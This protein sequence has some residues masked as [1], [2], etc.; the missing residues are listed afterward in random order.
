MSLS[1]VA[2]VL[3]APLIGED[4]VF[5]GVSTD[6]RSLQA[7][8]LFVAL[9]G[10]SYDGHNFLAAAMGAG[11]VGAIVSRSVTTPLPH[12]MTEDTRLA[13]GDLAAFWRRRFTVPVIAVTGSNGK[14]TVKEM[15]AAAMNET[16]AGLVTEGN[17]NNE[18][19]VPLTLLRLRQ[20]D[21]YAVVEMGMNHRGEIYYLTMLTRP[22]I[23]VITNASEAH[24]EGLGSVEA[25]AL[26][27]GEVYAG[28][29]PDGIAVINADDAYAGL[30][31]ELAENRKCLTFGLQHRA[32]VRGEY[33]LTATGS[34]VHLNTTQGDIDMRLR[35][36]GRHNVMNALAATTAS[37]AAGAGLVDIKKGLE[38]LRA[39][40]GRLEVK[41]GI[42]GARILDDTYNANPASVAVGLE[43]LREVF[44]ERVLV[45]GDMAEL[46][47]AAAGI[48]QRLGELAKRVG[49]NRLFAVGELSQYAV[50]SFGKGGRHFASHQALIE[51]LMDCMHTDMTILVKGSRIMHMERV[52]QGI[53]PRDPAGGE[54]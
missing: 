17:L 11:A 38:K 22:S 30:W 5:A 45:L 32:D 18:I 20:T 33:E 24:L 49:V 50:K 28:L 41:T 4:A 42:S 29:P 19:G 26:A 52:V 43:V 8:E 14:T 40:S 13:L 46:G 31:R 3:K 39:V 27:K 48:H 9:K 6:T 35:L 10:E 2:E 12:I 1:T 44:G 54:N 7:Q 36:L 21:N 47:E 15:I 16:A 23:A 25:I 37:L 53:L 51:E 34:L